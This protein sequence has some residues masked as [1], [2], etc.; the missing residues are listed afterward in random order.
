MQTEL[1]HTPDPLR[2]QLREIPAFRAL[3]RAVE[4][5]LFEQLELP[6]PVLDIGCGDGSFAALLRHRPLDYGLDPLESDVRDAVRRAGYRLAMVADGGRLP[7]ATSSFPTVISNSVIEHISAVDQVLL[8]VARVLVPGGQF[9]FSVPSEHFTRYLFG[10]SLLERLGLPELGKRYGEWHR[11]L[12]RAVHCLPPEAWQAKL[13][14][15]GLESIRWRYYFS[16][17][18]MNLFDIYHYLSTPA[19]LHRRLTGRWV[20]WPWLA[21]HSLTERWM[22]P[23]YEEDSQESGAYLFFVTRKSQITNRK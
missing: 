22:R 20:I 18:A 8:E 10:S 13:T 1:I 23:Y 21:E 17:A 5:R 3:L 11:R 6:R 14:A 12:A 19:L 9:I 7:F 16:R 4:C 15:A 2:R